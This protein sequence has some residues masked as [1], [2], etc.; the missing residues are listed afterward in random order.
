MK[1]VKITFTFLALFLVGNLAL[2]QAQPDITITKKVDLSADA[3]W[4]Q[5]R[6]L[7]NID[8]V[9][10]LVSKVEFTGPLAAA[11]G[12]RVCTNAEGNGY[13]KENIKAFSDAERSYT[14]H[15]AEGV[16]AKNMINNFK[17]VDLG[18]QSSMVV[19]TSSYEFMENPNMNQEQFVQFLTMAITE[20]IDNSIKNAKSM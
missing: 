14:Y 9:S 16:P 1:T 15:V 8:E 12:S 3:V 18:Y 20:M 7:D 11:G 10:S 6:I 2:A 19:W 4:E 17:I 5:I 13:F